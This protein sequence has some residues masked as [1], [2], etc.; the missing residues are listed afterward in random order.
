[1]DDSAKTAMLTYEED[2]VILREGEKQDEMYKILSGSVVV[3]MRYG[4]SDEHVVGIISKGR[5]F[6]EW[7]MFTGQPSEYTFVAYNQVLLMR[8]SRDSLEEFVCS[9][10]KNALDIMQNMAHSLTMMRKNIDLLLDEVYGKEI[11]N[12]KLTE[13][14]RRKVCYYNIRG[15]QAWPLTDYSSEA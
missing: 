3:Y 14:V 5:C 10:P 11:Q 8:V 12:Q 2:E 4:E 13:E 9:Y 6:G 7:N 1:M 15:W